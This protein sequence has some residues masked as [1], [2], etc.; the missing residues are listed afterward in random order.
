[1]KMN[2]NTN[3]EPDLFL[4]FSEYNYNNYKNDIVS[5]KRGDHI[6]FNATVLFEGNH[7]GIPLLEVYEMEKTGEGIKIN[8]HIHDQGR[9]S[10]GDDKVIKFLLYMIM[11]DVQSTNFEGNI[12]IEV[13]LSGAGSEFN[14]GLI[15]IDSFMF[16][17]QL[18]IH[19]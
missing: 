1:M 12:N 13:N 3:E 2:K 17:S 10:I 18:H 7:R 8:P 9:Y 4:K 6:R 19:Q 14:Q 15:S 5:M 11:N 16:L